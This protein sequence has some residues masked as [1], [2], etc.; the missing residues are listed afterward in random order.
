MKIDELVLN[1]KVIYRNE[2]IL[3]AI[4]ELVFKLN[5]IY[6]SREV[7]V[8]PVM[9]GALPFAGQ[10]IPKLNFNLHLDYFHASRYQGNKGTNSISIKYEPR[11]EKIKQKEVLLLDDILD[12]GHTLVFIRDRLV[13]QGAL[14]VKT[15]VLFDKV[16]EK[17]KPI[18]VDYFGLTVP[19]IYVYGFG[20]D[21]N[22][23]GRNM[24]HLYAYETKQS[25]EKK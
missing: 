1:S 14:S 7:T 25:S 5:S 24:S 22:E 21:F 19:N 8:L 17:A 3:N 13:K 4:D 23:I 12:E 20:L 9:T 6:E 11:E 18:N 2:E 10:L 15:A 16:I